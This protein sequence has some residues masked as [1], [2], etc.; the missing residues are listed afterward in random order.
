MTEDVLL[1][2]CTCPDEESALRIANTLVESGLAACANISQRVT[3]VY[4]WKGKTETASEHLLLIKTVARRYA[5]LE[6]C[7]KEHHPYELPELIAV[8]I[9]RGLP[10][11]L[12][13]VIQ[14]TTTA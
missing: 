3:S 14:C 9:D 10:A 7:I 8:P 5:A 11:Y 1:A 12:S 6:V 4:R 2:L 13:W